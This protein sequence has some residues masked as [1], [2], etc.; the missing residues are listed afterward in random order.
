MIDYANM[1]TVPS[2]PNMDSLKNLIWSKEDNIG[3]M[4]CFIKENDNPP[5]DPYN[6]Y[7]TIED[8]HCP[9]KFTEGM[10]GTHMVTIPIK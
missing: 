9:C 5:T 8:S 7:S 2:N 10:I 1:T 6:L 3:T 4:K